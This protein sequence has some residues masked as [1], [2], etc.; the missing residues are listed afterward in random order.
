MFKKITSIICTILGIATI[1]LGTKITAE[2]ADHSVEDDYFRYSAT[3]Y[4]LS[5]AKFGA[6]FYTY[7]YRGSDTIV[8]V[9]DDINKSTETVVKAEN[10]IYEVTAANIDAIDDLIDTIYIVGRIIVIAIGVMIFAYG[11]GNLGIAFTKTECFIAPAPSAPVDERPAMPEPE[12]KP[13]TE[14]AAK[15]ETEPVAK[16]ETEPA[17]EAEPEKKEE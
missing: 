14:P 17:A 16:P 4:D 9:L 8:D 11:I 2:P 6:D 1:V 7:I 10:G 12:T 15:P 13:E 5:S 3:D